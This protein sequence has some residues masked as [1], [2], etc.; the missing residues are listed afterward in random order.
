MNKTDVSQIKALFEAG[1]HLGHKKNRLHPKAKRYVYRVESGVSIIDLTMTADQL[2]AA[3]E[4]LKKCA[5]EEKTLLVVAT[6]KV[7]VQFTK[8]LCK[9]HGIP[10]ITNKWLP[11]L[12][13]N[14]ETI[15]K[16][17]KKLRELKEQRESGEWEKLVKHERIALNKQIVKLEKFYE[18]LISLDKKPDVLFILDIKKEKN[19]VI[20]AAKTGIPV[21]AVTDTNSDPS[22]VNYPIVAN[23]DSPLSV[24][25]LV[26]EIIKTYT[27]SKPKAKK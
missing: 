27:G 13:T 22:Q 24:Q 10:F 9:E 23:D 7:A 3:K 12:L 2:D 17:V 5:D 18:G 8:D 16:N 21:I 15:I 26:S 25:F 6:K 11:G 4:F 19:A 20:E 14:F 1:L